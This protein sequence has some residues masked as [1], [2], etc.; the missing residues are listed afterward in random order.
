MALLTDTFLK[1]PQPC[2]SRVKIDA[3]QQRRKAPPY[4]VANAL[5]TS[6]KARH[7]ALRHRLRRLPP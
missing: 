5:R 1:A 3:M 4:N 7:A 6:G 2:T